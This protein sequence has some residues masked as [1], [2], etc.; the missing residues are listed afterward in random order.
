MFPSHIDLNNI[1]KNMLIDLHIHTAEYSTCSKLDPEEAVLQAINVGLDGICFTDHESNQISAKAKKLSEKH[2]FLIIT[3]MELLTDKGDILVFGLDIVPPG[4]VPGQ[5]N[6][7]DV[8]SYIKQKG[9]ISISAHPFRK[10]QRGFEYY[11]KD[12]SGLTAIEAFNGNTSD[13]NNMKAYTISR[14]INKPV[15]GGSDSHSVDQIGC[16]ATYFN[17]NIRGINDFLIQIKTGIFYPVKK[18]INNTYKRLV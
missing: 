9:G 2:Q 8:I 4:F 14:E 7:L 5:T 16:Y 17:K 11:I 1:K 13:E 15:I 18:N 6:A 12:A 10:N 3:G